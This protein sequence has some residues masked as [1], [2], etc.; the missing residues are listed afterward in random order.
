M[1]ERLEATRRALWGD[2]A[3]D[4]GSTIIVTTHKTLQTW[5]TSVLTR[6]WYHPDFDLTKPDH[7]PPK[8]LIMANFVVDDPEVDDL[9]DIMPEA[10]YALVTGHQAKFPNWKHLS[11]ARQIASFKLF[12]KD[13]GG[14]VPDFE[15]YNELMR[16]NLGTYDCFTVDYGKIPFGFDNGDQGIYKNQHGK[17]FYVGVKNWVAQCHT[18][19]TFLTTEQMVAD[20]IGQSYLV[21][22]TKEGKHNAEKHSRRS[23]FVLTLTEVPPIYPLKVPMEIDNRAN[24]QELT[25]LCREIVQADDDALVIADGVHDQAPNVITFQGMK[26]LNDFTDKNIHVVIGYLSPAK[27]AELNILGQWIGKNDIIKCYYQDQLHQAV[28]RNRGFRLLNERETKTVIICSRRMWSSVVSKIQ[29][30]VQLYQ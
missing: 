11:R 25:E 26:G 13:I 9:I 23:P 17:R 1:Y 5:N 19:L 14:L 10:L 24:A 20:V 15:R 7:I 29:G 27:Y 21:R 30:R 6:T 16:T 18:R 12:R 28:G 2:G 8:N 3:C 4:G 22:K